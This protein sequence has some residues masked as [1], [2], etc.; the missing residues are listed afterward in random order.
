MEYIVYIVFIKL[1]FAIYNIKKHKYIYISIS[2]E[3]YILISF[4]LDIT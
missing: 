4:H 1:P 3:S 2:Y